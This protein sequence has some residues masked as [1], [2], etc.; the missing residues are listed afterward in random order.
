[1]EVTNIN[2]LKRGKKKAG[3]QPTKKQK[4]NRKKQK[5]KGVREK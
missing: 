2:D 5:N 4:G 3:G 1:V